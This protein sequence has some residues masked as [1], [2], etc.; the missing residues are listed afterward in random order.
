MPNADYDPTTLIGKTRFHAAD[1]DVKA[2]V[3]NA[4]FSDV[5]ITYTLSLSSNDPISSA[6][7][8][9]EALA[10]DSARLAFVI[11]SQGLKI[12][13]TELSNTLAARA[14]SLRMQ[15][16]V[17]GSVDSPDRVFTTDNATDSVI[18]SMTGW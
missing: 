18:G 4:T 3:D 2:P 9:L 15:A 12:D 6:A 7:W 17:G 11:Q 1:T 8:L 14:L 13:R 16:G 10:A 5:E